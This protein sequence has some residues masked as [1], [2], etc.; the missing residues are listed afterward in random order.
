MR[1]VLRHHSAN[2]T[3]GREQMILADDLGERLRPQAV[4]PRPRRVFLESTSFKQI[5]QCG[6]YS[7]IARGGA[8]TRRRGKTKKRKSGKAPSL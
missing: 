8:E 5:G 1:P 4:S 2:R 6:E 7:G 3:G